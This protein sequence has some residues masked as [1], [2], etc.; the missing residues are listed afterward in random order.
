LRQLN[1]SHYRDAQSATKLFNGI[2]VAAGFGAA[3]LA[4]GLLLLSQAGQKPR[5]NSEDDSVTPITVTLNKPLA[6]YVQ[7]D[8][9]SVLIRPHS[10]C[11]FTVIISDAQ[12]REE[13]AETVIKNSGTKVIPLTL[14]YPRDPDLDH[15]QILPAEGLKIGTDLKLEARAGSQSKM[16]IFAWKDPLQLVKTSELDAPDKNKP[17][18]IIGI[19]LEGVRRLLREQMQLKHERPGAGTE[20]I[21]DL[22][23]PQPAAAR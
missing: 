3:L 20:I 2:Q 12:T 21:V 17:N 19:P 7:G 14:F 10:K 13:S 5:N 18:A 11:Y 4:I 23:D 1:L 9:V 6:S 8:K 15:E 16:H 22:P